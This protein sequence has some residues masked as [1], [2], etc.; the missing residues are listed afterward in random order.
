MYCTPFAVFCQYIPLSSKIPVAFF[1]HSMYNGNISSK[2]GCPFMKQRIVSALLVALLVVCMLGGCNKAP[3][4]NEPTTT[5]TESTTTTT[6]TTTTTLPEL[7]VGQANPAL[8]NRLTG[9]YDNAAGINSR[10]VAIMV[11]NDRHQARPQVGLSQADLFVE[12]ETEGGYPRIMAVFS[13]ASRV[14]AQVAPVRS[15]RSHFVKVAQSLDAVYVYASGYKGVRAMLSELQSAGKLDCLNALGGGNAFWRDAEL[16]A[17][18]DFEHS[19]STGGSGLSGLIAKRQFRNTSQNTPFTFGETVAGDTCNKVT[20][21]LSGAETFSFAY[22]PETTRYTKHFGDGKPHTDTD[23][24]AIEVSNVLIM[25]DERYAEGA[26]HISFTLESGT[27]VLCSGGTTR[28][29]EWARTENGFSFTEN[30]KAATFLP[31]KT[32]IC[33]VSDKYKDGLIIE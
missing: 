24:N 19:L 7:S 33:L 8:Y 23:G 32:Y 5:T 15:A 14:P 31:G 3:A 21:K 26:T 1:P 13:D 6:T 2:K 18:R 27:A 30:G 4:T 25:Y 16:R 22:D 28:N 12:A 17:S 11:A 29:V 9:E 20:V 10:P